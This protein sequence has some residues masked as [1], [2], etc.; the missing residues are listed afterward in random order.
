M[1]NIFVILIALVGLTANAQITTVDY[2]DRLVL[3]HSLE[4]E[5]AQ[6][7]GIDSNNEVVKTGKRIEDIITD[8]KVF[9]VGIFTYKTDDTIPNGALMPLESEVFLGSESM[10]SNPSDGRIA[11][12]QNGI[13]KIEVN[14]MIRDGKSAGTVTV[15]SNDVV[16]T[17]QVSSSGR[18]YYYSFYEEFDVS[19]PDVYIRVSNAFQSSHYEVIIQVQKIK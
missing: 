2:K 1:R 7:L 9:S 14:V 17:M 19:S 12:T 13:Y 10:F 11:I 16:K 15:M 5:E 18:Q 3:R 4:K 6:L 8:S